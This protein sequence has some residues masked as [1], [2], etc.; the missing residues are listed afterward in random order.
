[1]TDAWVTRS[2]RNCELTGRQISGQ[3]DR[4]PGRAASETPCREPSFG[5]CDTPEAV[6]YQ[7]M[8]IALERYWADYGCVLAQPYHTELAAG[9]MNPNTFLRSLGPKPRPVSQIRWRMPPSM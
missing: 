8:I 7:E 1:M 3:I 5:K 2:R 9:T 4:P 6:N